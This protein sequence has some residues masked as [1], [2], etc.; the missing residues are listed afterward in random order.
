MVTVD[1]PPRVAQAAAERQLGPVVTATKGS[2][3]FGNFAFGLVLTVLLFGAMVLVG[4][5][6]WAAVRPAVIA[7]LALSLLAAYYTVVS[8]LSGFRRYFLFAGGI[9]RWANGRIMAFG[10]HDVI[11]VQRTRLR[12]TQTGFQFSLAGGRKMYVE[13]VGNTD[14]GAEFAREIE[15][16]FTGAGVQAWG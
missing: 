8:L 3:P 4:S 16:A 5:R 6:G 2:N 12:S 9:V 11:G 14:D 15:R 10:W 13:A 1:V 7:L